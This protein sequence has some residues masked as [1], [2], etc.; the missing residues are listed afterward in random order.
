MLIDVDNDRYEEAYMTMACKFCKH[1]IDPASMKDANGYC[2]E[3]GAHVHTNIT[4]TCATCGYA[5]TLCKT[6]VDA[7]TYDNTNKATAKP[8]T[9]C[10]VCGMASGSCTAEPEHDFA[11]VLTPTADGYCDVCATD[12]S[13]YMAEGG[14]GNTMTSGGG[15]SHGAGYVLEMDANGNYV[16]VVSPTGAG[17]SYNGPNTAKVSELLANKPE[18]KITFALE[19]AKD[20]DFAKTLFLDIRTRGNKDP[21]DS[22]QIFYTTSDG[23]LLNANKGTTLH[24][25]T[26]TLTKFYVTLDFDN[27]QQ[28]YYNADGEVILVTYRAM[29][30]AH[31]NGSLLNMRFSNGGNAAIRFGDIN[32]VEG[33]PFV[34]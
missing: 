32:V 14:L 10:D 30:L 11:D 19:V 6:H 33:N 31:F 15:E 4:D 25:L 23:K 7:Y 26:E 5:A 34:N 28:I 17:P 22:F 3:C 9:L 13:K 20:P 16:R 8:D 2:T 21:M 1:V 29:T 27:N 24:T 12:L 18:K